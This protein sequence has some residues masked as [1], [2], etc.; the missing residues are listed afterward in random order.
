MYSDT[1]WLDGDTWETVQ[2]D[3]ERLQKE[4]AD[5]MDPASI[6]MLEKMIEGA[7]C[8]VAP[9]HDSYDGKHL[10]AKCEDLIAA[11][12]DV[13]KLVDNA[14]ESFCMP[15]V[16][17]STDWHSRS[18]ARKMQLMANLC[19][20][21]E[22]RRS[23]SSIAG[24][25]MLRRILQIQL[26]LAELLQTEED[27]SPVEMA[28]RVA[29]LFRDKEEAID[30]IDELVG[31]TLDMTADERARKTVVNK[32]R[33]L[34]M[35]HNQ[36]V[37]RPQCT[38]ATQ[39]GEDTWIDRIVRTGTLFLFPGAPIQKPSTKF[40]IIP[41]WAENVLSSPIHQPPNSPR[42]T[43][44]SAWRM[45]GDMLSPRIV[46][47]RGRFSPRIAD[48]P[49]RTSVRAKSTSPTRHESLTSSWSTGRQL[50]DGERVKPYTPASPAEAD[51]SSAKST[52]LESDESNQSPD[53]PINSP[54]ISIGPS[55][56]P[57]LG[58]ESCRVDRCVR[59]CVCFPLPPDALLDTGT[60]NII[61]TSNL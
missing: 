47:P 46:T 26:L 42:F 45:G 20:T 38:V 23:S 3:N 7:L 55:A 4:L 15:D 2:E 29:L 54:H 5:A 61:P 30:I 9:S 27:I 21:L 6:R 10:L 52:S 32:V 8:K 33:E 14:L 43:G 37:D 57:A 18:L 56:V 24:E 13:G 16:R 41:A 53:F 36:R 25:Q 39:T 59:I 49:N 34:A 22:D 48:D 50:A 58:L 12:G 51:N 35:A 31:D 40:T 28:K 19:S 44:R 11:L 1:R 17:E 60:W